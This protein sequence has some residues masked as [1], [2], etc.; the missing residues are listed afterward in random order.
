M[1]WASSDNVG[2][3]SNGGG[4]PGTGIGGIGRASDGA[5]GNFGGG[6]GGNN[7]SFGSL[8]SGTYGI[9]SFGGFDAGYG[10]GFGDGGFGGFSAPEIN[11]SPLQQINPATTA[12]ELSDMFVDPLSE[13]ERLKRIGLSAI[14]PVI[15]QALPGPLGGLAGN[16]LGVAA[17]TQ[18]QGQM[19]KNMFG[20]IASALG[21]ALGGPLG[22]LVGGLLGRQVGNPTGPAP[23]RAEGQNSNGFN[24]M[25]AV[26]GLASL[27]MNNRAARD[28]KNT[29]NSINQGVEQQLSGMFGPNSA[30]A[31]QLRQQLDRR[32]AAA[33]RRSQYGPR[34]VELQAKLAELAARTAPSLMQAQTQQSQAALQAKNAQRQRQA[35]TLNVLDRIGRTSGIYNRVGQGLSGLFDR[36]PS[37]IDVMGDGVWG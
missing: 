23:G 34:E 16:A 29:A 7:R 11:F 37:T 32:D 31:Q 14:G 6:Y 28:A 8:G 22:G 13:E 12:P 2:P 30:Y 24:P 20:N 1:A 36:Q 21:T 4:G 9:D 27:Y 3:G 25:D 26:G 10:G 19:A 33:G 35:Q 17:G 5:T 18:T 15:G